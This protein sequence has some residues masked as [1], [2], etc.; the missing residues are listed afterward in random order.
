M[1]SPAQPSR[2]AFTLIELVLVMAI[3]AIALAI[4]APNLNGWNHGSQLRNAGD[5]F[6]TIARYAKAQAISQ[7]KIFRLNV[8][9]GAGHYWLTVQQA[10]DQFGPVDSEY[11]QIYSMTDGMQLAMTDLQNKPINSVDFYPSG[12]VTPAHVRIT[13]APG[14]GAVDLECATPAEGFAYVTQGAAS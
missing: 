12:R 5:Q 8:D 2:H 9:P 10:Q 14:V 3:I 6:L 13:G 4:A 1:R 11:G 7:G